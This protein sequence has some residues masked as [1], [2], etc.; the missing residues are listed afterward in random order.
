MFTKEYTIKV[1]RKVASANI[2]K[3]EPK[4]S[5]FYLSNK[6]VDRKLVVNESLENIIYS[7]DRKP[8]SLVIYSNTLNILVTQFEKDGT[9]LFRLNAFP[10]KGSYEEFVKDIDTY[11]II[12]EDGE[13]AVI[14]NEDKPNSTY[15][16][17]ITNPI[18]RSNKGI[19]VRK[20]TNR[21]KITISNINSEKAVVQL[22]S[23]SLFE[24]ILHK[25]YVE[26]PESIIYINNIQYYLYNHSFNILD[27]EEIKDDNSPKDP[28]VGFTEEYHLQDNYN[29]VKYTSWRSNLLFDIKIETDL[30]FYLNTASTNKT[31]LI[32]CTKEE[33]Y[34][35]NLVHLFSVLY[36][37]NTDSTL[38]KN[39]YN[40][41]EVRTPLGENYTI[42]TNTYNQS[43]YSD[44]NYIK[45]GTNALKLNI[46]KALTMES[47]YL[48]VDG[49][50]IKQKNV[51]SNQEMFESVAYRFD[52]A[53]GMY[54]LLGLLRY[55]NN[56]G[57]IDGFRTYYRDYGDN[58]KW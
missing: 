37:K 58:V 46:D 30:H 32:Y 20:L 38:T 18:E 35:H 25:N 14:H 29:V 33:D 53:Y 4:D 52:R 3:T 8:N 42:L 40:E 34:D 55:S 13:Y 17:N 50:E 21:F 54:D 47:S 6:G 57:S 22:R 26:I 7:I 56:D 31:D 12:E 23:K 48:I 36:V 45:F 9:P 44:Y 10:D 39:P 16:Y 5:T 2:I 49:A 27:K 11:E 15:F 24:P 28:V 51:L 41:R 1:H 43:K 19:K